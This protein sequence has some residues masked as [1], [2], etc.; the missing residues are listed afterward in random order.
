MNSLSKC[1]TLS[2]SNDSQLCINSDLLTTDN[3]AMKL[4]STII[5]NNDSTDRYV[6]NFKNEL[7]STNEQN[8]P[9]NLC[10]RDQS[11]SYYT[12]CSA[13]GN[14][15]INN[16]Y[17]SNINFHNIN[18]VTDNKSNIV[19]SSNNSFYFADITNK[20]NTGYLTNMNC[21]TNN[22]MT[23]PDFKLPPESLNSVL[24]MNCNNIYQ[25]INFNDNNH[26]NNIKS[27]SM[28]STIR[29]PSPTIE[30]SKIDDVFL[31]STPVWCNQIKND[32][33]MITFSRQDIKEQQC[34]KETSAMNINR[35][36]WRKYSRHLN[37]LS[38]SR[39]KVLYAQR[40]I[41][42]KLNNCLDGNRTSSD[43]INDNG[44]EDNRIRQCEKRSN[45]RRRRVGWRGTTICAKCGLIF[46]GMNHLN[47]H[48]SLVHGNFLASEFHST[49]YSNNKTSK[50]L[51]QAQLDLL[52]S[53]KAIKDEHIS[54]S[55]LANDIDNPN[56]KN[57]SP[58]NDKKDHCVNPTSNNLISEQLSEQVIT[59]E[60]INNQQMKGYPCPRCN[61]TAKWPTE[62]QKHVMVHANSRP[63]VCCVCATSYKWSWDLGRHFTNSHP[64]LPNPYKRQRIGKQC[65]QKQDN[66]LLNE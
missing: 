6:G 19:N 1:T 44:S 38:N 41:D 3:T 13:E 26:Y 59:K 16:V 27:N 55:T 53:E 32:T 45:G 62:L 43:D 49:Q 8:E 61:Y 15:M 47:T 33:K 63:F 17:T 22:N 23:L 20:I 31:T 56:Q 51:F 37:R 12:Q 35:V 52:M 18:F 14:D 36:K 25:T 34:G 10:I 9:M 58:G 65:L 24:R 7:Y 28:Y 66:L 60:I 40:K 48:Y 46:E 4:T 29:T 57:S 21:I 64:N 39:N 5:N 2:D 30:K 50:L 54:V 42:H 11:K